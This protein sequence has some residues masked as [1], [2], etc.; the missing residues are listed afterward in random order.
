MGQI[1]IGGEGVGLHTDS[2]LRLAAGDGTVGL[3][4]GDVEAA[5]LE[6][7]GAAV[8]GDERPGMPVTGVAA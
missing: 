2:I 7:E 1:E 6:G 8:G 3:L 5:G 4:R